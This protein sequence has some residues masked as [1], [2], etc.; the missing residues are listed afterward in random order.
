MSIAIKPETVIGFDS[1]GSR[2]TD[3][4]FEFLITRYIRS[5]LRMN[6]S[7]LIPN[8]FRTLRMMLPFDCCTDDSFSL[9]IWYC[10][11]PWNTISSSIN[12]SRKNRRTSVVLWDRWRFE[13]YRKIWRASSGVKAFLRVDRRRIAC[14]GLDLIIPSSSRKKK[15]LLIDASILRMV[16]YLTLLPIR[17]WR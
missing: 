3:S 2:N 11:R 13:R 5:L 10:L 16:E 6:P 7:S 17:C 1:K 4:E 9:G 15:N 8:P 14:E 12:S